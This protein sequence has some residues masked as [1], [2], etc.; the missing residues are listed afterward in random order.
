MTRADIPA[1]R[2]EWIVD[3]YHVGT[4]A[5]TIAADIT[6][7]CTGPDWTPARTRAAVAVAV[8]RHEANRRLY[9]H[10]TRGM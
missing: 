5:E 4:P 7:R 6:A 3:R 10:V 8:R 9:A 1:A 2:I